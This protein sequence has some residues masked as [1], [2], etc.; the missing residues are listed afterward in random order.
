MHKEV[1]VRSK[2]RILI[3]ILIVVVVALYL[4]RIIDIFRFNNNI[5]F[6]T[7]DIG[8][9]AITTVILIYELLTVN[10][11]YKYSIIADKLIVNR[12]IFKKEKNLISIK[13]NDILYVGDGK[14]MP[15]ELKGKY[16]G[17]YTC[18]MIQ[19]G[20]KICVFKNGDNLYKFKF[21]AS[22]RLVGKLNAR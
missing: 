15:K 1:I 10:L 3:S 8:L 20:D 22:D 11:K 19:Y 13:I 2:I 5:G 12:R 14:D 9:W 21:D 16:I 4:E 7:T 18:N 6:T 17:K